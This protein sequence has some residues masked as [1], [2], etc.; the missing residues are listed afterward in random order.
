MK[1]SHSALKRSNLA[2]QIYFYLSTGFIIAVCIYFIY[3]FNNSEKK[4]DFSFIFSLMSLSVASI[5]LITSSF[6][7]VNKSKAEVAH[8]FSKNADQS[9]SLIIHNTSQQDLNIHTIYFHQWFLHESI[10]ELVTIKSNEYIE[11]ALTKHQ[12]SN[13]KISHNLVLTTTIKKI[14]SK[15]FKQELGS[16]GEEI[17]KILNQ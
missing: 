10:R 1:L 5:A 15:Y 14:N 8:T 13:Y 17:A 16:G 9:V 7:Q 3:L 4:L 6:F 2:A 11:I 12:A